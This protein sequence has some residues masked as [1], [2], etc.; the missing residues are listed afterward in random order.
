M[1]QALA[2]YWVHR[3]EIDGAIPTKQTIENYLIISQTA[4]PAAAI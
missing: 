4:L 1:N 2:F 3:Q